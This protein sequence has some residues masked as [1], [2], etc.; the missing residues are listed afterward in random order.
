M[1]HALR[2]LAGNADWRSA[3]ALLLSIALLV[4]VVLLPGVFFPYVVPRN[5]LFRVAVE[6]GVVV[7]VLAV[8][9]GW[10]LSLRREHILHALVAFLAAATLS[11]IFSP[12][13][14]HSLFG[15]FERMGGVWAWLHLTLFFLLLRVMS[16]RQWRWLL[17]VAVAV[18]VAVSGME[19]VSRI[20]APDGNRPTSWILL[21]S[22]TLGNPG[23][24]AGYLLFGVAF[25]MYLAIESP[26]WR[27]LYL[28]LAAI[29]LTA[30]VLAQNRSSVIG[31][32]AGGTVAAFVL[33]VTAARTRRRWLGPVVAIAVGILVSSIIVLLRVSPENPLAGTVP[34]VISRIA[35]TNFD[36]MDASR[37]MQWTAAIDGFQDRPLLGYGPDNH[38]LVWSAHFDPRMDRLTTEV[39]DR[40]HNQFLEILATTGLIGTLAFASIW[41]AVGWTLFSGYR[42]HRL[43]SGGLAVFAG[44]QVAYATYLVFWFVDLNAGMLWIMCAALLASRA[45]AVPVVRAPAEDRAVRAATNGWARNGLVAGSI[46][47]L[48][49]LVYFHAVEPLR[50]SMA[51][52]RIDGRR[53][54]VE[55]SL[56]DFEIVAGSR[57]PQTSLSA[58]TLAQYLGWL[59]PRFEEMREDS[60]QRQLL[61]RAFAQTLD[62]FDAEVRRDPLNDRLYTHQGALLML[63]ADY[64]VSPAYRDRAVVALKK[65]VALSPRR[66][67]QRQLLDRAL[68]RY[69]PPAA[70][71]QRGGS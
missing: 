23:L 24:L 37:T 1:R 8:G 39:F 45:A 54:S 41:I 38:H 36:G 5:I 44:L 68:T 60:V 55:E 40:T 20:L 18:S 43:T 27:P 67:R 16:D 33:A 49:A 7:L 12:A 14:N 69:S 19:L 15:D 56:R 10:R 66:A 30:L 47:A 4:P 63:A 57:A 32:L 52:S 13:R 48:A 46:A 64:F 2:A 28:S 53:G 71:P 29:D 11:A 21:H 62:A 50:T 17:N 35:N 3:I 9:R 58:I 22:S 26:R 6:T 42:S 59:R 51:L 65:A 34:K 25:S 70:A 31:L 61:D